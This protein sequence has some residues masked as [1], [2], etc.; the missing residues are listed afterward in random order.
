M[1]EYAFDGA[2]ASL[3]SNIVEFSTPASQFPLGADCCLV[4]WGTQ[5]SHRL[6]LLLVLWNGF[7]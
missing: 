6:S 7:G 5:A 1:N 4:G 2:Q 3:S